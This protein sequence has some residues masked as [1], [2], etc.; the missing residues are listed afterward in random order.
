MPTHGQSG[1][2]ADRSRQVGVEG[3]KKRVSFAAS[4]GTSE[5]LAYL[6]G[7]VEAGRLHPVI[8]RRFPLEQMVEAHRYAETG[9][10]L[11]NVV[12]VVA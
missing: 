12:V 7:L 5:D 6:R 1:L 11:G 8:D 4:S 9:Q 3:S 2:L 10:K